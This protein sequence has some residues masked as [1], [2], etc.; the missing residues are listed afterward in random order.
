[1]AYIVAAYWRAKPGQEETIR[2]VLEIMTPLSLQEPGCLFYQPHR[3]PDDPRL[4]F[5]YEQYADEAAYEAH[6]AT[7]HFEQ[8]VKGEAIPNLE[9][10]ERHF[11]WTL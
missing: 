8:Y 3:S 7:P 1:M 4:F 5:I 11:F 2:R 6:M 9:S 10:R